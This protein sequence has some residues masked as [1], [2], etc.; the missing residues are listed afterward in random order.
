MATPNATVSAGSAAVR[1]QQ[2]SYGQTAVGVTRLKQAVYP[3]RAPFHPSAQYPEYPFSSCISRE[4]NLVYDGVRRLLRIL[5]LDASAFGTRN[6][7]P[8]GQLIRP[9]MS[10]V[11]KPNWVLSRHKEEKS[12]YSIITHP[13]VLRAIAD[14][15]WIALQGSGSISIAD[16]P[17][18]DCNFPELLEVTQLDTV[19]RFYAQFPGPSVD[20]IDLRNYWSAGKHFASMLQPLSGDPKGSLRINLGRASAF[21][22]KQNLDSIY[23]AVYNRAETRTHHQGE[24]HIYELSKTIFDADVVICVPK[25]KVHKKVGVTLNAK[26]L[27]GT[28]TNKNLIIHYTL[29][30]PHGGGDQY[31]DGVLSP[32][33]ERLIK[34]ERWMYDHFLA[35][36]RKPLEYLHRS[37]YWLHNHTTKRLGLK[38]AEEKR[39]LDAGNWYGNDSAWRMTLDLLRLFYFADRGGNLR[40][41]P[42]RRIFCVIDGVIGGENCGPLTPDPVAAGLLVG[43]DNALAVDLVAT[44]LMGFDPYKLKMYSHALQHKECD[45][46]VRTLDDIHIHSDEPLMR[47]CLVQDC[48]GASR[49]TPHPGWIGH[50][51]I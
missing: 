44:R 30:S 33:E 42:Q 34:T 9:G 8:L 49:F 18:Y 19:R 38:V 39:A 45:F 11:I 21:C 27:V 3:E 41:T 25:L 35:T 37:I 24:N 51:E 23:G 2:R 7:N 31:P 46:G 29:G 5:Q 14:Y 48:S 16:A 12:V 1:S 6:W 22:E 17:Q 28:A 32:L 36:R 20:V 15:C 4:P 10:V 26:G 50:I 43:G 40:N 47:S 13:A